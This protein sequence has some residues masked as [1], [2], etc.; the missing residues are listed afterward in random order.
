MKWPLG[1]AI[2]FR[3]VYFYQVGVRFNKLI[4]VRTAFV[5]N[6]VD[7]AS[8]YPDSKSYSASWNNVNCRVRDTK[9]VDTR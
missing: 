4:K 5:H 6:I 7:K 1:T 8:F 3:F 9:D 2:A